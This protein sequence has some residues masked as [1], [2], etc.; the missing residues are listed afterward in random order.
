MGF[1]VSRPSEDEGTIQN[2]D[3]VITGPDE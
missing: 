3:A 2:V 1:E